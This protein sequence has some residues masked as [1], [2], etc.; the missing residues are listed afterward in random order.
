MA[1]QGQRQVGVDAALVK[2]VENHNVHTLKCSVVHQHSCQNAFGQY[3]NPCLARHL[4]L[5]S[6]PIAYGQSNGFAYHLSHTFG[7]LSG[8]ESARFEHQHLACSVM[9]VS[10]IVQPCHYGKR[11]QRRLTGTWRRCH[12]YRA[13]L[14]QRLVHV[15]SNLRSGQREVMAYYFI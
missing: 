11:Q 5:K 2:L 8:G 15:S 13:V 1:C 7:Y 6:Y 14:L 4:A 12:N 3:L 9:A 10:A